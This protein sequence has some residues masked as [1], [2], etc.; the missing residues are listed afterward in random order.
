[1]TDVNH[2]KSQAAL[3]A[4]EFVESGM[5]L[6]LGTGSTSFY[7]LQE[8]GKRIRDRKLK[9]IIGIPSSIKAAQHARKLGIPIG[10]LNDHPVIDLTIDGADEVDPNLNLI[11][12]GGGALLRE[13][14]LAQNSRKVVIIVDESKL[15]PV[16]GVK[17]DVPIETIPFSYRPILNY[18]ESLDSSAKLRKK[19][20]GLPFETDQGN[21]IIDCKFGPIAKPLQLAEKLKQKAG[22]VEHGLFLGLATDVIVAG[23]NGIQ[24]IIAEREG[25]SE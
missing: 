3:K 25:H 11:K 1:M 20:R 16:L 7:A 19:E 24:H 18:I 22:I 4:V 12:G 10:S 5:V 15:S 13:K 17:R 14:I 9:S 21:Y 8:I 2:L 23:E 6:G